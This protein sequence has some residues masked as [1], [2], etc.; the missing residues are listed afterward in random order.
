MMRILMNLAALLLAVCSV[1]AARAASRELE[2]RLVYRVPPG[3]PEADAFLAQLN[4][5]VAHGGNNYLEGA[6]VVTPDV[7]GGFRLWIHFNGGRPDELRGE[8]CDELISRAV[9]MGGMART[10]SPHERAEEQMQSA[11]AIAPDPQIWTDH[12][13]YPVPPVR[14]DE[15]RMKREVQLSR[16]KVWRASVLAHGQWVNGALPHP[17]LG[18][19]VTGAASF[20]RLQARLEATIWPDQHLESVSE[21]RFDEVSIEQQA[22]ALGLCYDLNAGL[23]PFSLAACARGGLVRLEST[24]SR[25]YSAAV[26]PYANVGARLGIAWRYS[27]F[28]VE[29]LGGVDVIVGDPTLPFSGLEVEFAP[30]DGQQALAL[31]MGWEF[32][33]PARDHRVASTGQELARAD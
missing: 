33:T 26:V 27:G 17:R 18:W 19:G 28:Y 22:L 4:E 21:R 3:C 30:R 31:S 11:I 16:D 25:D 32:G 12:Q 29:F 15:S 6:I 1:R 5:H 20:G 24:A 23:E 13:P 7:G 9:L 14:V 2:F 10:D 8:N